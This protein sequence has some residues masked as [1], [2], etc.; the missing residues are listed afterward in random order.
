M[1]YFLYNICTMGLS[2]EF[3]PPTSFEN[4]PDSTTRLAELYANIAMTDIFVSGAAITSRGVLEYLYPFSEDLQMRNVDP[5]NRELLKQGRI[6]NVRPDELETTAIDTSHP[7]YIY[8]IPPRSAERLAFQRHI[9]RGGLLLSSSILLYHGLDGDGNPVTD[10]ITETFNLMRGLR[11]AAIKKMQE[12][13]I[14]FKKITKPLLTIVKNTLVDMSKN[15]G[16]K[17]ITD[18][19]NESRREMRV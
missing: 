12:E 14:D 4:D 5:Q 3:G 10:N 8:V 11:E 15:F 2:T 9:G 17:N 19:I 1:A 16:V 13:G 7:L 6:I 18:A